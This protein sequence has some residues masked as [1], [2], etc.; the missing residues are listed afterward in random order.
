MTRR[1]SVLWR[2]ARAEGRD[3]DS[4]LGPDPQPVP[5]AACTASLSTFISGYCLLS[6]FDQICLPL[7]LT[8]KAPPTPACRLTCPTCSGHFMINSVA[9]QAARGQVLQGTQYVMSTVT[10]LP[11]SN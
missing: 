10:F 11:L 8:S 3:R 9:I 7:T 4:T 5:T 1:P 2:I 6:S